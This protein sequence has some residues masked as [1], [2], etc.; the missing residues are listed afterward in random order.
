MNGRMVDGETMVAVQNRDYAARW[1]VIRRD[2]TCQDGVCSC[3]VNVQT[4]EV[5]AF[6]CRRHD[7]RERR[8]A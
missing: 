5:L 7:L 2:G 3:D 1:L 6:P 8:A 4:G